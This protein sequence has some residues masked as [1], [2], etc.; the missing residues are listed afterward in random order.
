MQK[1]KTESLSLEELRGYAGF[2]NLSNEELR[3]ALNF[4]EDTA[5]LLQSIN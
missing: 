2:E 3:H 1:Q 5:E 4:I